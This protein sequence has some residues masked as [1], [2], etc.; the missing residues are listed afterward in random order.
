MYKDI[1]KIIVVKEINKKAI[2]YVYNT[3]PNAEVFIE[4]EL[5]INLIDHDLVPEH[6]ILSKEECDELLENYNAKKRNLPKILK[7][8]PVARYYNMKPGDICKIIRPSEQS[9]FVAFYRLVV[10]N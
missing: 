2:Q 7:T 3:F 8:D 6:E 10:N 9:G 4:N 1:P 5:L